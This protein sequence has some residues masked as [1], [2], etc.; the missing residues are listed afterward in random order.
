MKDTK[1]IATW[2]FA[3]GWIK[4]MWEHFIV[5][6]YDALEQ[7]NYELARVKIINLVN[8]TLYY[9]QK[10]KINEPIKNLKVIMNS[11]VS[12]EYRN[13]V[14]DSNNVKVKQIKQNVVQAMY[15]IL[16]SINYMFAGLGCFVNVKNYNAITESMRMT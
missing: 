6:A 7:K 14:K 5:P 16:E 8:S 4:S 10:A 12:D 15:S 3:D 9:Q 1:L 13:A 2:N 11:I